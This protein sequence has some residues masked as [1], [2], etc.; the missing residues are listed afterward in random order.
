[1]HW[2]KQKKACKNKLFSFYKGFQKGGAENNAYL[3]FFLFVNTTQYECK[4]NCVAFK[5]DGSFFG[6]VI[7][8]RYHL[9]S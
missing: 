4:R 6:R 1:M 8:V 5:T 2:E 3:L 7:V 9:A